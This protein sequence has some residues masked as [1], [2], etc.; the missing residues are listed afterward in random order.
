MLRAPGAPTLSRFAGRYQQAVS[1][2]SALLAT[3]TTRPAPILPPAPPCLQV[4]RILQCVDGC[5]LLVD[6]LEGPMP[7][8]RYVLQC[9]LRAGLHPIVVF[10]KCDREGGECFAALRACCVGRGPGTPLPW[11]RDAHA[12]ASMAPPS[13]SKEPAV[14]MAGPVPRARPPA[15]P[16]SPRA[17]ALPA[18][19]RRRAAR[20]LYVPVP[21]MWLA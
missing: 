3:V 20:A 11:W 21:T 12:V 9:A 17:P 16:P 10:N 19:P 13:R 15:G 8:T 4:Q 2:T 18:R 6:A 7:Q 1:R 14:S 5:L